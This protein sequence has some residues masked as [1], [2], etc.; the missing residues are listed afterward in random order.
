V[1]LSVT[2]T[3]DTTAPEAHP[4]GGVAWS[5]GM[6]TSA[7]ASPDNWDVRRVETFVVRMWVPGSAAHTPLRD[8]HGVVRH[9]SSGTEVTFRDADALV[10]SLRKLLIGTADQ[11]APR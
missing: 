9:V 3:R 1:R 2:G 5:S 11:E 6:E 8:L 7:S 4:K 10:A